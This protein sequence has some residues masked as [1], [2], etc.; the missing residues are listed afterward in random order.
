VPGRIASL[1][2]LQNGTRLC[3]VAVIAA[4]RPSATLNRA[5]D[6]F[7][8]LRPHG[9]REAEAAY[10]KDPTLGL[11]Q[12]D[13]TALL[14]RMVM[15]TALLA[16]MRLSNLVEANKDVIEFQ[17]PMAAQRACCEAPAQARFCPADD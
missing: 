9:W 8:A 4:V 16:P 3:A 15:C 12:L 5:R 1:H 11:Q 17:M 14:L 13:L 6:A 2:H 10:V 7:E